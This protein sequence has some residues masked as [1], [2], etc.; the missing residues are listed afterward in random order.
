MKKYFYSNLAFLLFVNLL[1]KPFWILGIDRTVQNTIG[2]ESYGLYFALFNFSVLFQILLDFGINNFNN[3]AVAQDRDFIARHLSDIVAIKLLLAVTYALITLFCA[4][5]LRYDSHSVFLLALLVVSQIISSFLLYVRSNI[6][7]MQLF[8]TDSI[9]SVLDKLLMIALCGWLLWGPLRDQFSIEWFIYAQIATLTVTLLAASLI[10][11]LHSPERK[12]KW[13]F[14]GIKEIFKRTYPYALLGLLMSIYYR[15][16][17]VM[18]ERML[19]DGKSEAGIY[20]ASF[21]LLDTANMLGFLFATILLPMFARMLSEKQ[22]VH[23]LASSGFKTIMTAGMPIVTACFFYR[24][25]IISLLYHESNPYWAD[26]FG[27]LMPSFLGVCT[28]YIYGSLL[29]ANGS[30]KALNSIALGGMML[31]VILNFILIPPYKAVG[32]TVATLITQTLVAL[33]HIYAVKKILPFGIN[34]KQVAIFLA[35]TA[36]MIIVFWVS[37]KITDVWAF[38]VLIGLIISVALMQVLRIIEVTKLAD[39][40]RERSASR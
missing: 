20:A 26:V 10:T 11:I 32:A 33:A 22:D 18:L 7:G 13:K 37:R 29:T 2:A 8:K 23:P 35:Y 12:A 9:I 28:V 6:S 25:E 16:D 38:N 5:V 24:H 40:V 19:A 31:N 27:L 14:S 3:R 36:G 17:G 39:L 30:I 15:V 21:R 34:V 1:V 4:F